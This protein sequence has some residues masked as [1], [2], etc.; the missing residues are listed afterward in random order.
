[1]C[2]GSKKQDSRAAL[3]YT[4][5]DWRNCESEYSEWNLLGLPI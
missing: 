1:M 2:T 5:S 3:V 4:G